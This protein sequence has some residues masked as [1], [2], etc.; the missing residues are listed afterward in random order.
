MRVRSRKGAF[1]MFRTI[2][3]FGAMGTLVSPVPGLAQPQVQTAEPV[4]L[5]FAL[6]MLFGSG[7]LFVESNVATL[8]GHTHNGHFNGSFESAVGPLNTALANQ[9]VAA[10]TPP[11]VSVSG[12]GFDTAGL[13]GPSQQLFGFILSERA[14]LIGRGELALGLSVQHSQFDSLDGLDLGAI[15]ATFTHDNFELG[16]GR[17]D[18][19]TTVN[20]LDLR[21]T[22]YVGF[23]SYGLTEWVDLS[24]SVPIVQTDFTITSLATL[25][26][27]GTSANPN[28][29]FFGE[30]TTELGD[31]RTYVVGGQA[32]GL[33]DIM[34]RVKGQ[35]ANFGS[36]RVALGVDVRFPTGDEENLLG[37]GAAGVRPFAV[38][39]LANDTVSPHAN[40][41]YQ[42]NGASVLAGDVMTSEAADFPDELA[43]AVGA[44]VAITR[45]SNLT[46]DLLGRHVFNAL[47]LTREDF[48][49][50]TGG[51]FANIKF[52]TRSLSMVNA[53]VGFSVRTHAAMTAYASALFA[54][55]DSGLRS[56]VVPMAGLQYGF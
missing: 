19:V 43:Y 11:P 44:A 41:S 15:P 27:L 32:T 54:L 21:L 55:N 14:E 13:F 1:P 22:Q 6:P 25:R 4:K 29:H 33:G 40:V 51:R 48:V 26:R 7:G 31:T 52:M 5:A 9:L 2:I 24:V 16:G 30:Q 53:A 3:L 45:R 20:A 17:A 56:T 49:A 38:W 35:A 42:W 37:S 10:P 28:V 34:V 47:R 36:S 12:Y 50:D 18:V 8:D 46:F 23:L 39:S